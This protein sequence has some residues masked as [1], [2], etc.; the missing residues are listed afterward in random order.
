MVLHAF[1][2]NFVMTPQQMQENFQWPPFYC[3]FSSHDP[4]PPTCITSERFLMLLLQRFRLQLINTI[5]P[6]IILAIILVIVTA[7]NVAK[8]VLET[9]AFNR[10]FT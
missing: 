2:H 1:I 5:M 7:Q 3:T 8:I 4:P 6:T 10:N 9:M